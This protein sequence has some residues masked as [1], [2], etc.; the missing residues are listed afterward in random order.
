MKLS[1][2]DLT[3]TD[4]AFNLAAEQ[5]AVRSRHKAAKGTRERISPLP[6][7]HFLFSAFFARAV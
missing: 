3:T 6:L 2:L 4:P 5:G 7:A 1:Y